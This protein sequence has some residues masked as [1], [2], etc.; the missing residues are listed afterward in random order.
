M[1]HA[2]PKPNIDPASAGSGSFPFP[3]LGK[4]FGFGYSPSMEFTEQL[5]AVR[6]RID[7][8]C[9]RVGRSPGEI[10]VMAVTK[11]QPP[12]RVE[13]A[14]KAGLTLF[15]EN[16][17]QE[18]R[19]KIPLCPNR[20]DWHMIG[21]LQ[22]N[23]CREALQSFSMIQSVDSLKLAQELDKWAEKLA[24]TAKVLIEVNVAGESSKFGY[25]PDR[26]CEEFEAL[27]SLRRLEIHGLMT[28]APWSPDPERARPYFKRLR[29]SKLRCEEVL[30]APL[31]H[32]SM[33]MSG[34]FEVAIEEG[35]TMVRLGTLLFGSRPRKEEVEQFG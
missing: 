3:R 2:F 29:E 20:L 12:A 22:S 10:Q 27:N 34:D 35:A 26:V 13:E 11:G 18:A 33:G 28:M 7:A 32:L 17:V 16:K 15:G 24:K 14:A 23:K 25:S 9:L 19:N 8:A 1:A 30:G 21:H 31:A 5:A 4:G 6:S